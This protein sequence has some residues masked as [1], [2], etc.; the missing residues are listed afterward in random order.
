MELRIFTCDAITCEV[1]RGCSARL[2]ESQSATQKL[3][4][5]ERDRMAF[6]LFAA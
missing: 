2:R 4:T 5:A 6:L 3:V 1:L